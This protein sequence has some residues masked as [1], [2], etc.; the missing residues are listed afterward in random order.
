MRSNYKRKLK[1]L[2]TEQLEKQVDKLLSESL[3]FSSEKDIDRARS[4]YFY[5]KNL[6]RNRWFIEHGEQ[7]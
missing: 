6:L 4:R 2:T 3:S 5:A 1:E 7:N